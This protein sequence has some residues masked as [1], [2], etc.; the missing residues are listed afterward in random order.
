[1]NSWNSEQ[2]HS[3]YSSQSLGFLTRVSPTRVNINPPLLANTIRDLVHSGNLNPNDPSTLKRAKDIVAAL[4][5]KPQSLFQQPTFGYVAQ[6][7]SELGDTEA[8]Q[9]LLN[10]ADQFMNPAWENGGLYYPRNDKR[11]DKEGNWVFVD[12]FT[13]NA[14]IGYSRLNVPGGQKAMW[15]K[16]WTKEEVETRPWVDG[17]CFSDGVDVLRGMWIEEEEAMVLTL[18]T[19]DGGEE[20]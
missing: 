3:S 2:V 10:H 14:A 19:W 17:I 6:W 4:P 11:E 13:G 9:G 12:P 15:E 7:V 20:R 18:R 1:M 5:P 16:P 8:L